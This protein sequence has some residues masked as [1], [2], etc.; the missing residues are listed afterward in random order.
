MAK[1]KEQTKKEIKILALTCDI[2]G[3][4]LQSSH[5]MSF[6]MIDNF[7]K[8]LAQLLVWMFSENLRHEESRTTAR[9]YTMFS[10]YY[11]KRVLLSKET[12][13]IVFII[14]LQTPYQ[15]HGS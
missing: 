5:T 15:I 6:C 7:L 4:F 3:I 1:H 11:I 2:G 9:A 10:S 12:K 13:S 14:D 8:E